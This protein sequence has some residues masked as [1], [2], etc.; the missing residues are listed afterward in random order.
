M[1]S[2]L[3]SNVFELYSRERFLRT[4]PE[5]F[6]NL[7]YPTLTCIYTLSQDADQYN[8]VLF[9]TEDGVLVPCEELVDFIV[10]LQVGVSGRSLERS[11]RAWCP[12]R[13]TNTTRPPP[14]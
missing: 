7:L 3:F 8:C 9:D 11:A 12:G 6:A 10:T 1:S 13:A 5:T 4:L 2:L 14:V